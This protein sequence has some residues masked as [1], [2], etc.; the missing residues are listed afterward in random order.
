MTSPRLST[1]QRIGDWALWLFF[2]A[3]FAVV[4]SHG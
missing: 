1:G 4:I 3:F 2:C